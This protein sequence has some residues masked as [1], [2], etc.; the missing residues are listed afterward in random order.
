[1]CASPTVYNPLQIGTGR[2]CVPVH[3]GSL[4]TVIRS[5][6]GNLSFRR[7]ETSFRQLHSRLFPDGCL[8]YSMVGFEFEESMICGHGEPEDGGDSHE[9]DFER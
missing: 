5:P 4:F 8:L 1:M 7:Y 9:E 6:F 2:V 3:S